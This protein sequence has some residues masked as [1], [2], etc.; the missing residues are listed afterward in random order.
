M[1]LYLRR[2]TEHGIIFI[3]ASAS[4]WLFFHTG[5]VKSTPADSV[6]SSHVKLRCIFLLL[7][8]VAL[9]SSCT[10]QKRH[11]RNGFYCDRK[12]SEQQSSLIERHDT[13][14][15]SGNT[16]EVQSEE[17]KVGA[18]APVRFDS[19]GER[20]KEFHTP[21]FPDSGATMENESVPG[22]DAARADEPKPESHDRINPKMAA[23]MISG[24]V[25]SLLFLLI[26]VFAIAGSAPFFFIIAPLIGVLLFAGALLLRNRYVARTA[27]G[28]KSEGLR[29]SAHFHR[30]R[31]ML[32]LF[33]AGA[34]AMAI[35]WAFAVGGGFSLA[36]AGIIAVLLG[37]SGMIIVQG[38]AVILLILA[39]LYLFRWRKDPTGYKPPRNP[40]PRKDR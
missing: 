25:L 1:L 20:R 22:P 37:G 6:S 36:A 24:V 21:V 12:R 9:I 35:G 40:H 4:S 33:F 34:L 16:V 26:D 10:I 2:H 13:L 23:M 29:L 17:S 38:V 39:L 27:S 30:F 7:C 14:T 11:Y 3:R 18:E 15:E 28:E 19:S 31:I 32:F 5:R 8:C